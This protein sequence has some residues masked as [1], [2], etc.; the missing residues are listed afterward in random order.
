VYRD[1]YSRAIHLDS[2]PGDM[3]SAVAAIWLFGVDKRARGGR[4]FLV[5]KS[6][7]V[8]GH[9]NIAMAR[10]TRLCSPVVERLVHNLGLPAG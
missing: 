5:P 3:K 1:Q 9:D 6:P 10:D 7:F 8:G 2:R 4:V